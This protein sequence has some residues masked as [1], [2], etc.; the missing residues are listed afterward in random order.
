MSDD[1]SIDKVAIE[2]GWDGIQGM[3]GE[4]KLLSTRTMTRLTGRS[5]ETLQR[6]LSVGLIKEKPFLASHGRGGGGVTY[7]WPLSSA[8]DALF[9]KHKNS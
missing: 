8:V 2:Q 7:W 5:G 3:N 6:W 4:P 9:V 1:W